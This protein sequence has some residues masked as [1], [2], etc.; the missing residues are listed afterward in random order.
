MIYN[1]FFL[2]IYFYLWPQ[3]RLCPWAPL[4]ALVTCTPPCPLWTQLATPLITRGPST[5]QPR[6]Q[7]T[8]GQAQ[9]PPSRCSTASPCPAR[10]DSRDLKQGPTLVREAPSGLWR[11]TPR[12][13]CSLMFPK[14]A[15]VIRTTLQW[16]L[17]HTGVS[18]STYLT[19]S[20]NFHGEG[21]VTSSPVPVYIVLF[22][23][24][25]MINNDELKTPCNLCMWLISISNLNIRYSHFRGT[26]MCE[27][28]G[29]LYTSVAA[30]RQW[31]LSLQ[32]LWS[33]L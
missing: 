18:I 16:P 17:Q 27:L 25:Q 32:C 21:R 29:D 33:L 13:C 12:L 11:L 2:F 24:S 6:G 15:H 23:Y 30:G 4:W 14:P 22:T 28:R 8:R 5:P 31:S 19:I 7:P 20:S 10:A 1:L 3:S 9:R 26:R